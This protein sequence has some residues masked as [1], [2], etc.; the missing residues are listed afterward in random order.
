MRAIMEVCMRSAAEVDAALTSNLALSALA[1]D[2]A[3]RLARLCETQ[4]AGLRKL[5]EALNAVLKKD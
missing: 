3:Q 5:Q 1:V 4:L 2:E